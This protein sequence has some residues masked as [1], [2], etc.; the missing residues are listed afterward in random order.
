[1]LAW[2]SES[3]RGTADEEGCVRFTIYE[4]GQAVYGDKPTGKHGIE[5]SSRRIQPRAHFENSSSASM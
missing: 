3:L 5:R 4:L 1:M 2:L